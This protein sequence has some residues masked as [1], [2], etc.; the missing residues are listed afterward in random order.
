M[1]S[2]ETP[3]EVAR[4]KAA[5]DL[6]DLFRAKL[7]A[8]TLRTQADLAKKSNLSKSTI[9]ALFTGERNTSWDAVEIVARA[10]D[11]SPEWLD[12]VLAGWQD[13]D[14][15]WRGGTPIRNPAA[16]EHAECTPG[17]QSEAGRPHPMAQSTHLLANEGLQSRSSRW[18]SPTAYG[19]FVLF[20]VAV[21]GA[22]WLVGSQNAKT[23]VSSP[24]TIA[25][26]RGH[27]PTEGWVSVLAPAEAPPRPVSHGVWA[28]WSNAAD[29]V[30]ANKRSI[31]L[32]VQGT[33]S[34]AVTLTDLRLRVI[35]RRPA[36]HGT[37]YFVGGSGPAFRWVSFDID[38][39]PPAVSAHYFEP[40]AKNMPL[41]ERRP[42]RFPY[43]VSIEESE[44]LLVEVRARECDCEFTIELDWASQG[45]AH[46]EILNDEGKPF[47]VTGLANVD[48]SC[49][50]RA[51]PHL[52]DCSPRK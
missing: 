20:V 24:L 29:A 31:I 50:A 13:A 49:A 19:C 18:N 11:D 33:S 26:N 21:C 37:R 14:G 16:R 32:T 2:R 28:G 41:Q 17:P 6:G 47:R 36:V 43:E 40:Y 39:V 12:R 45:R 5:R 4:P 30:P 22:A 38:S 1:A 35:Q 34:A 27:N 52:E 46:T 42:I 10:M 7:Q 44:S 23:D 15:A 3:R 9:S 8:S 48:I 51:L 25:V